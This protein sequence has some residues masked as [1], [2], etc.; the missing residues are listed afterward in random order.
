MSI[1]TKQS[2]I[3]KVFSRVHPRLCGLNRITCAANLRI[4][5]S[6]AIRSSARFS[7]VSRPAISAAAAASRISFGLLAGHRE[8]H[9]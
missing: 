9:L 4:H 8:G 6:L 1:S 3:G 7:P 2:P 5:V